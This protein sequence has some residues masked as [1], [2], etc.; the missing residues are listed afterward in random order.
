[1]EFVQPIQP[2]QTPR[3]CWKCSN[4]ASVFL[5]TVAVDG[6]RDKSSKAPACSYHEKDPHPALAKRKR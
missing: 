5:F 6:S 3:R 2:Q 1:M 4:P